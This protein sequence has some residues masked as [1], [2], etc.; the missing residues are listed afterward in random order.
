MTGRNRA[1][2]WSKLIWLT[3]V[4]QAL[5]AS[6]FTLGR[7]GAYQPYFPSPWLLAGVIMG[8]VAAGVL[9]LTLLRPFPAAGQY[10]LV[11]VLTGVLAW[12]VLRGGGTLARQLVALACAISFPVL[13]MTWQLDRWRSRGPQPGSPLWRIL[14]DGLGA[15]TI[16]VLLSLA[17]GLF[18]AAVLGDVRF[19]MEMEIFRG[20]KLTFVAPPLLFALIYLTRY[21]LFAGEDAAGPTGVGRQLLK[22]LDYPVYLKTLIVCAVAAAAAWIF[23]GRSGHTSGVP[24]PEFELKFRAALERLMYARP[25]EKEFL[26]GH[27]AF[28]LSVMAFYRQW[29]R[30]LHFGLLIIATIGQGSLVETFAHIR[31]PVLMS[32][33]RGIDGLIAGAVIGIIAVV[34]VQ[35]LHY[36]SFMLERGPAD[37]E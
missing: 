35:V 18:V 11:A 37:N 32:A 7:A 6:G 13:A 10:I 8:A 14:R 20:V 30:W 19:L 17:G 5:L 4:K 1:K 27:P 26:I 33:V 21:N 31:T 24:V 28:L 12:P 36:L 22:M 23:I 15:L 29:P 9:L 34:G 3:A 16:T 2:P 25:R